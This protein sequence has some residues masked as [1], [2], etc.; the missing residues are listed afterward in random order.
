MRFIGTIAVTAAILGSAVAAAVAMGAH[1]GSAASPAE[2]GTPAQHHMTM[3]MSMPASRNTPDLPAAQLAKARLAPANYATDLDAAKADG[4]RPLTQQIPGMG[5][6]FINPTISGFDVRKPPILVY[7]KH[8]SRWQ[9]G[10]LEWVF[11]QT[12]ATPPLKGA[13]YGA[14]PAACHFD[15]G[16][17]A[18]TASQDGCA[19]KSPTSGSPFNFWHPDLVTMHVWIWYPNPDGM[20]A[21]MNPLVNAFS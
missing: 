7:E 18:V 20:Y 19:V 4:Y 13:I 21:S 12:P 14:F 15:D 16:T 6:H 17:F 3:G 11:P 1:T 10:A 2:Y 9:L 5:Y 8:G